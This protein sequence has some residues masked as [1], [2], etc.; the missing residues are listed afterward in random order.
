M[1]FLPRPRETHGTFDEMKKITDFFRRKTF[2]D[3]RNSV[4]RADYEQ[5]AQMHNCSPQHVYEIA[6]GKRVKEFDD[7]LVREALVM[8]GILLQRPLQE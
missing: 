6:H 5:I 1:S 8:A 7:R 2:G 3:Y 4:H